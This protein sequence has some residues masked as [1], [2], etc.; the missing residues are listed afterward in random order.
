LTLSGDNKEI[1]GYTTLNP[2]WVPLVRLMLHVFIGFFIFLVIGFTAVILD[3][4][5]YWLNGVIES[6]II[7][8]GLLLAKI[9]IFAIDLL[10][11]LMF[12][13]NIAWEFIRSLSW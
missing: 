1:T 3:L 5:I 7:I 12:L 4:I 10:L 13:I 9:F 2:W 8:Y 11:F 6:T